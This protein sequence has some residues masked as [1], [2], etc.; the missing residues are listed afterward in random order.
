MGILRKKSV[1]GKR[2]EKGGKINIAKDKKK[3]EKKNRNKIALSQ[4]LQKNKPKTNCKHKSKS[5]KKSLKKKDKK[6]RKK[7]MGLLLSKP[8]TDC[9]IESREND[10]F[11]F[12]SAAMQG[13]RLKMEGIL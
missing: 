4:Q 2:K 3:K 13:W 11:A 7:K 8:N 12:A 9:T 5:L 1:K 10:R 6:K